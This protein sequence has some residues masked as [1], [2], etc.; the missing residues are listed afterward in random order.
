MLK[1]RWSSDRL[2]FNMGI[3]IPGKDSLILRRGPDSM[4][5]KHGDPSYSHR[6]QHHNV[7]VQEGSHSQ[8]WWTLAACCDGGLLW[9]I[10][11]TDWPLGDLIKFSIR[12]CQAN[13]ND[14]WLRY[15]WQNW[16]EMNITGPYWWKVNIGLGNALV[17][18][19]NKPLPQ[20]MLTQIYAAIWR[21]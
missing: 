8:H 2:I 21:H 4:Q 7:T 10:L 3:P 11:L 14:W 6:S 16:P 15:L 1:I 5:Q 13:F 18:S 9:N 17:T 20:P 19:G 12:N